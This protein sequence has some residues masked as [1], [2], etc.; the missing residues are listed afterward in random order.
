MLGYGLLPNESDPVTHFAHG[1]LVDVEGEGRGRVRHKGVVH[2][3]SEE[4][5][6]MVEYLDA[7]GFWWSV[8][9]SACVRA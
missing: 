1:D 9:R 2:F 4:P 3:A 5:R 6:V 7:P 8:L